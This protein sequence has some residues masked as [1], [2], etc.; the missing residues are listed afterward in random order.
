M[1]YIGN[2]EYDEA[3]Q[4]EEQIVICG[5]GND[6][7]KIVKKLIEKRLMKKVV[8]ICDNNPQKWNTQQEGIWIESYE[9]AYQKYPNASYIVYNR[10]KIAICRQIQNYVKRIHFLWVD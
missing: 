2:L 10:Y 4:K 7:S 6:L 8:V 5:A 9:S 1:E 3:L